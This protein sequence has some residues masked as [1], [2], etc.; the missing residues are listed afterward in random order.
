MYVSEVVNEPQIRAPLSAKQTGLPWAFGVRWLVGCV[1]LAGLAPWFSVVPSA[2][3]L[4]CDRDCVVTAMS[5]PI[6]PILLSAPLLLMRGAVA[7]WPWCFV[8]VGVGCCWV[9]GFGLFGFV[10][11]HGHPACTRGSF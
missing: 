8:F 9:C 3:S 7:G 10:F 5:C 11:L 4:H 1:G 2:L 6:G